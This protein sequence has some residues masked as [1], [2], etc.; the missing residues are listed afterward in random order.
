MQPGRAWRRIALVSAIVGVGVSAYLLVEYLSN[1]GGVCLT[2]GGCDAVRTSAFA[3]PLGIPMPLFGVL[4]YVAAAWTT[5]R[6]TDPARL[7]GR[8]P[9]LLLAAL[10]A[11]GIAV[12]AFLT[13]IEAFVIHAYCTWCLVQAG[14]ALTLGLASFR[15]VGARG[16]PMTARDASRRARRQ[17]ERASEHERRS[18]RRYGAVTSGSM[19]VLVVGLLASS[20][21]TAGGATPSPS[22]GI[23]LAPSS[24]P[25]IGHGP[26]TVVEF[27]DFQCPACAETSPLLQALVDDGSITLVYRY[28]PLPQHPLA[29][30]T[31]TAAA[32]AAL[33]GKF[34]PLHDKIFATQAAWTNL[35]ETGATE[36]MTQLATQAGLDLAR[37]QRDWQSAA[38]AETVTTDATAASKLTLPQTPS[39]F[40]NGTFYKGNLTAGDLRSAVAAGG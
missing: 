22:V 1:T 32:A 35:N 34:W 19:A 24:S 15:G 13:G 25:H 33:Q 6:T 2:G 38:V 39:I 21:L 29:Q 4:F 12:S 3:Y 9:R 40:I 20:T 30:L 14:A 26:V 17:A 37:W 10:G 18:L 31:A 5:W 8:D 16:E 36:Y 7:A 23:D 11:V 28:F 27:A